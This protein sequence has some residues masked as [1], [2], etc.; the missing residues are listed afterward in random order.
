MTALIKSHWNDLRESL[1][2][3]IKAT[4][5]QVALAKEFHVTKA[6]VSQWLSGANMP[7]AEIALSLFKRVKDWESEPNKNPASVVAPAGP[8]TRKLKSHL[9]E[10]S[11]RVRKRK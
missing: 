5:T 3:Y 1:P 2:A 7:S 9:Y 6:A 8:K 4:G 11:K 10:K